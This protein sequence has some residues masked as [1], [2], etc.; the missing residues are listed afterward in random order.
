MAVTALGTRAALVAVVALILVAGAL[1]PGP[2]DSPA[3]AGGL[4]QTPTTQTPEQMAPADHGRAPGPT[5]VS[6]VDA[7]EFAL[8]NPAVRAL[9]TR[10]Q[11]NLE[12]RL[13]LHQLLAENNLSA[14]QDPDRFGISEDRPPAVLLYVNLTIMAEIEAELNRV[15]ALLAQPVPEPGSCVSVVRS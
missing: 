10:H 13:R 3:R 1:A 2:G 8:G 15:R 7:R 12:Q 9:L 11:A 4:A 6:L 14:L 5:P